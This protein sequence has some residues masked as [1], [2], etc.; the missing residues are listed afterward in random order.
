MTV[1]RRIEIEKDIIKMIVTQALARGWQVSV[2]DGEE[3]VVTHATDSKV[4][5]EA[6]MSTD[7]DILA[8][9]DKELERVGTILLVYGNSGHD[10]VCDH[11]C[12]PQME[13]FMEF[14][15]EYASKFENEE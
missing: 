13:A 4:I 14:I 15:F 7:E 1:E 8:F 11:S 10:V 2:N 9:R 12:S 6:V 5:M 3:W